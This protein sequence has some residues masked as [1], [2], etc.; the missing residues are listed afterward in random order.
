MAPQVISQGL[1][2]RAS[3]FGVGLQGAYGV[4]LQGAYQEAV[5]G[6]VTMM[7]VPPFIDHNGQSAQLSRRHALLASPQE[8]IS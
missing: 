2:Q 1:H 6:G 4:G 8:P 5:E 7:V 3:A